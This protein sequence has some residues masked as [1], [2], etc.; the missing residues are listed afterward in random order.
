MTLAPAGQ[1]TS[2]LPV[3]LLRKTH[4]TLHVPGLLLLRRS[5]HPLLDCRVRRL[6]VSMVFDHLLVI[7]RW[8]GRMRTVT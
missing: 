5:M 3:H 4:F 1:S 2:S 8:V 7:T 6:R